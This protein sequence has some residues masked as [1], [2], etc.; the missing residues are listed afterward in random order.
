MQKYSYVALTPEG[1][2]IR[3]TMIAQSDEEIK[4]LVT[5]N[6]NY[7][8]SYTRLKDESKG[9]KPLPIKAYLNSLLV[10]NVQLYHGKH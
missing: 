10:L 2:T 4:Q 7:C 3:G 8:L 5:K 1:K 9:Q 6:G